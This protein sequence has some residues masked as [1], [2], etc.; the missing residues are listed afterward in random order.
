MLAQLPMA[1]SAPPAAKGN[2]TGRGNAARASSGNAGYRAQQCRAPCARS[3][4]LVSGRGSRAVWLYSTLAGGKED[5]AHPSRRYG[6][7]WIA[8]SAEWPELPASFYARTHALNG[9]ANAGTL[10]VQLDT[11][12]QAPPPFAW[13][14][15][16]QR[17]QKFLQQRRRAWKHRHSGKRPVSHR[18]R[19]WRR[20]Y[21]LCARR[22]R[23]LPMPMPA[24]HSMVFTG[25]FIGEKRFCCSAEHPATAKS[26]I[27]ARWKRVRLKGRVG[28]LFHPDR[29]RLQAGE[30][31]I[32]VDV[33]FF[34]GGNASA[35]LCPGRRQENTAAPS[36]LSRWP[37]YKLNA[38]FPT[39]VR[40]R[41][42]LYKDAAFDVCRVITPTHLHALGRYPPQYS[43][44]FRRR[45]HGGACGLAFQRSNRG[46]CT[47]DCPL[48]SD[49]RSRPRR[50]ILVAKPLP[51]GHAAAHH[52]ILP[53]RGD[54]R[55]ADLWRKGK[56]ALSTHQPQRLGPLRGGPPLLAQIEAAVELSCTRMWTKRAHSP[57]PVQSRHGETVSLLPRALDGLFE[58][59]TLGVPWRR[60]AD[61]AC[62]GLRLTLSLPPFGLCTVRITRS[63]SAV[64]IVFMD[65]RLVISTAEPGAL[66]ARLHRP[67]EATA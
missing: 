27:P 44:P 35:R 13:K 51:E 66:C 33:E 22:I 7:A 12:A 38:W 28:A 56:T 36:F 24:S 58:L 53:H 54:W 23:N 41:G 21:H 63:G 31:A 42:A 46:I 15:P 26:R 52:S 48:E 65:W 57:A 45:I 43:P 1:G 39:P 20:P 16:T 4:L 55:A 47:W 49:P 25:Y 10:L 9:S 67:E 59:C 5:C 62:G 30:R 61:A 11:K 6:R 50:R 60:F 18:L 64:E 29:D 17:P 3:V 2:I 19:S 32:A 37:R 14:P 8:R 34:S 40:H